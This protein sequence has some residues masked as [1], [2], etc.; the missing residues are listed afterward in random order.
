M[1]NILKGKGFKKNFLVSF[2]VFMMLFSTISSTVSAT[3]V[4][5]DSSSVSDIIYTEEH[6][7]ETIEKSSEYS[8]L[9]ITTLETKEVEYVESYLK[10]GEYYHIVT[11]TEGKFLVDKED[12]KLSVTNIN[13]DAKE[14]F[15]VTIE[16]VTKES[17]GHGLVHPT[18]D[19]SPW[20]WQGT[21]YYNEM[22]RQASQGLT[23]A[24]IAM[25]VGLPAWVG[26]VLAFKTY[27][28]ATGK[29]TA[30]WSEQL[31]YHTDDWTNTKTIYTGYR[32]NDYRGILET[33]TKRERGP[34]WNREIWYE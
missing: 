31:Y 14:F 16:T 34:M 30:Y 11:N 6:K 17:L 26:L 23:L 32:T 28:D 25:V 2:I 13:T 24:F 5:S 27:L 7:Y 20:E 33:T 12:D 8:K 21:R 10:D 29:S 18:D 19:W 3:S 15:D 4:S 22:V 9:K 1:I